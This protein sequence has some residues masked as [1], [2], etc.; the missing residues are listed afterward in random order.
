MR[1]ALR[2]VRPRACAAAVAAALALVCCLGPSYADI[3]VVSPRGMTLDEAVQFALENHPAL[4]TVEQGVRVQETGLMQAWAM[5]DLTI[6]ASLN[7]TARGPVHE[8]LHAQPADRRDGELSR[9]AH[10]SPGTSTCLSP[11]P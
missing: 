10:P 6:D 5:D 4:A 1:E 9:L 7:L 11:S 2:W 8:H 3:T